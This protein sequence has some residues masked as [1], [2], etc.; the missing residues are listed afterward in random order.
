[1]A[2]RTLCKYVQK[3]CVL[4]HTCDTVLLVNVLKC[5]C[6]CVQHAELMF[7]GRGKCMVNK[8]R[9]ITQNQKEILTHLNFFRKRIKF[10]NKSFIDNI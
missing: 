8:I 7:N 1:M 5:V 4:I 3:R 6:V 9:S 10:L 2:G